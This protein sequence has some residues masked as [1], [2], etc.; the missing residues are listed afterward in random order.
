MQYPAPHPPRL[1]NKIKFKHLHNTSVPDPLPHHHEQDRHLMGKCLNLAMQTHRH[2]DMV[3]VQTLILGGAYVTSTDVSG[4][5]FSP[6][7]SSTLM[8]MFYA[9]Y[10]LN[11]V[12]W[13]NPGTRFKCKQEMGRFKL[14]LD[15]K[16][17]ISSLQR[18]AA[19]TVCQVYEKEEIQKLW[20][21]Q[22]SD[23]VKKCLF[24]KEMDA[25]QEYSEAGILLPMM[26]DED[27]TT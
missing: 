1:E 10:N 5:T 19:V 27:P 12:N 2:F 14:W 7:F 26:K 4:I 11:R 17:R 9:G 6:G 20:N 22:L 16:G 18:M 15:N 13:D 21:I 8:L 25:E 24:L 3:L 23:E